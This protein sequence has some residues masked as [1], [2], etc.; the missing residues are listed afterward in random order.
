MMASFIGLTLF[1]FGFLH[2]LSSLG[3]NLLV[4]FDFL[5]YFDESLFLTF[6]LSE[7]T[8]KLSSE[9]VFLSVAPLFTFSTTKSSRSPIYIS[10]TKFSVHDVSHTIN[11]P[12]ISSHSVY[13]IIRLEISLLTVSIFSVTEFNKSIAFGFSS[14]KMANNLD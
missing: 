9:F 10:T 12:A 4:L 14:F 11:L 13:T 7:F 2:L 6:F 8:L 5:L 1:R 3:F